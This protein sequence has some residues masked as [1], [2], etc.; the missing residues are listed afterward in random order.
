MYNIE[1]LRSSQFHP[2]NARIGGKRRFSK[3]VPQ[4]GP[5][6]PVTRRRIRNV[7]PWVDK[8]P[9]L[10]RENEHTLSLLEAMFKG[11]MMLDEPLSKYFPIQD[12]KHP[13]KTYDLMPFDKNIENG[14][15]RALHLKYRPAY[16]NAVSYK[17]SDTTLKDCLMTNKVLDYCDLGNMATDSFISHFFPQRIRNATIYGVTVIDD[18]TR[19][20]FTPEI[21]HELA[22][23][24]QLHDLR[25]VLEQHSN[26]FVEMMD[27]PE[28]QIGILKSKTVTTPEF[29][30]LTTD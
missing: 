7:R 20:L 29:V 19:V 5:N 26:F 24:Q 8:L 1:L 21:L 2:K 25:K 12:P 23:N 10:G 3:V 11:A 22:N 14:I 27:I 18:L 15:L 28:S 6:A 4:E 30:T 17:F 13:R 9:E 16:D